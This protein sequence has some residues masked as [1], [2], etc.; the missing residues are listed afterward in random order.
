MEY[1]DKRK[2]LVDLFLKVCQFTVR[3]NKLLY[4]QVITDGL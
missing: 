3:I 1:T 2:R 4:H